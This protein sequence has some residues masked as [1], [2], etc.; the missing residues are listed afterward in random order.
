MSYLLTNVRYFYVDFLLAETEVVMTTLLSSHVKDKNCFLT[1]YG[2]FRQ[3][4]N[5][6]ISS[7]SIY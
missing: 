6:G 1:E 5:A 4:K 3:W 2:N 7:V